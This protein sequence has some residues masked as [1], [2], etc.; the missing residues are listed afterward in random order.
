M[1]IRE[2][3]VGPA[4]AA[5][6]EPRYGAGRFLRGG[7]PGRE[8]GRNER[9]V[10]GQHLAPRG[11]AVA[12]AVEGDPI[13]VLIISERAEPDSRLGRAL[14]EAGAS[15]GATR[16]PRLDQAIAR[17]GRDA[18]DVV[19]LDLGSSGEQ[20]LADFV[21]LQAA[22][23][24]VPVV[25]LT[26]AQHEVVAMKA[27]QVGAQDY[28]LDER[29]HATLLLRCLRHAVERHRLLDELDRRARLWE[30]ER[31]EADDTTVSTASLFGDVPIRRSAPDIFEAHVARYALLL[32]AALEEHVYRVARTVPGDLRRI[33][34]ELGFLRAGPRDV[35]DIHTTALRRKQPTTQARRYAAY[36]AE[37]R[38]MV[39]ELMGHLVSHYRRH[40]LGSRPRS[41]APVT[42]AASAARRDA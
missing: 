29:L 6:F 34:D 2:A 22:Q 11:P 31:R 8:R 26:G 20:G 18:H 41:T 9:I 3:P 14:D 23:S 21:R 5:H 12:R 42:A 24:D 25:V 4:V 27:V 15:V 13:K 28:L 7:R 1:R 35:V 40:S 36:V 16:V 39:L 37:S 38:M 10:A 19:L 32:D 33:A 17:L 30:D